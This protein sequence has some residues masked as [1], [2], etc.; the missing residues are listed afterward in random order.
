MSKISD[1]WN[2][3]K[4]NKDGASGRKLSAFWAIVV[5]STFATY[6]YTTD[7]NLIEVLIIWLTF[8]SICLGLVTIPELIKF[9]AELKNGKKE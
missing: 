3:F 2:S 1:I 9:L 6:K 8:A 5:V 4:H 7:N